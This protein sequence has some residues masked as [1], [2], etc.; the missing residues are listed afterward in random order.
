MNPDVEIHRALHHAGNFH[1]ARPLAV[2]EGDIGGEPTT[3]GFLSGFFAGAAGRLGA[4]DRQRPAADRLGDATTPPATPISPAKRSDSEP[5]SPRCTAIWWP[6]S[7]RS[8]CPRTRGARR[9]RHDRRGAP[10]GRLRAVDRRAAARRSRR[11]STG[12][13]AVRPGGRAAGAR[14]P[15]PRPDAAHPDRLGGHRLRGRAGEE[16]GRNARSATWRPRTSPACSAPSTTPPTTCARPDGHAAS[17]SPP[18]RT[19]RRREPGGVPATATARRSGT[20]RSS[21]PE[22]ITA[23]ELDKAVYEVAYEYSNRPSWEPIPLHAVQTLTSDPPPFGGIA[24]TDETATPK[25]RR[26]AATPKA[27]APAS[28]GAVDPVAVDRPEGGRRRSRPTRRRWR[29]R[30]PSRRAQPGEEGTGTG[31]AHRRATAAT[32]SRPRDEA[33][34]APLAPPGSVQRAGAAQ[35]QVDRRPR[36]SRSPRPAARRAGR[37]PPPRCASSPDGP[38]EEEYQR[39]IGGAHHDP[40]SILGVA[41][42]RRRQERGAHPA[43][44]RPPGRA[45]ARRRPRSISRAPTAASGPRSST[46]R[47]ATTGCGSPTTTATATPSTTRTAGCRRSARWTST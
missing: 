18:P 33:E 27:D 1:V 11:R 41:P 15:A 4:G 12:P 39:L 40:H 35:D 16:P 23:F 13:V 46:A 47:S 34:V 44:R 45:A 25:P 37:T 2:M 36:R 38:S 28:A 7:A 30:R 20:A 6:N 3:L 14:R 29:R 21:P 17:R 9:R 26:R 19:G 42:A 8:N 31:P 24:V 32:G 5:P 43:A 10:G 22:V